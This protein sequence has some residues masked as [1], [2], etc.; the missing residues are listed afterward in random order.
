MIV[1]FF[2]PFETPSKKNSRVTDSRTGR[3]F[4]SKLYREWHS[5]ALAALVAQKRP[6][7]PISGRVRIS[8]RFVRKDRRRRDLNNSGASI[9]DLL[10]DAGILADDNDEVVAVEE[11]LKV[12]VCKARPSC[13]VTITDNLEG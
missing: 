12:G 9:L 8:G 5:V 2:L 6:L 11:W 3:T 10:V 13:T 1:K 7:E 4:P